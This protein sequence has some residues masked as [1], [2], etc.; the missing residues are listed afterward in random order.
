MSDSDDDFEGALVNP[1]RADPDWEPWHATAVGVQGGPDDDSTSEDSDIAT[2]EDPETMP[3]I[4][5]CQNCRHRNIAFLS[6]TTTKCFH[7]I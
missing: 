4:C 7:V 3:E 2:G 5:I 1:Y 6:T